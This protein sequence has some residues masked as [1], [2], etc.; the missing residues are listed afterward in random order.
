MEKYMQLQIQWKS[1]KLNTRNIDPTE[2][3]QSK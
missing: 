3:Q 2:K 1:F